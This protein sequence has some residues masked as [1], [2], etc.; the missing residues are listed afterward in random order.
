M[1]ECECE[2]DKDKSEAGHNFIV[3]PKTLVGNLVCTG[4]NPLSSLQFFP[5]SYLLSSWVLL[6]FPIL[7]SCPLLWGLSLPSH[8]PFLLPSLFPT[9]LA[10]LPTPL[11][12]FPDGSQR[13]KSFPSFPTLAADSR[14]PF[15]EPPRPS[16]IDRMVFPGVP[17]VSENDRPFFPEFPWRFPA[18]PLAFCVL[19]RSSASQT[20]QKRST[21]K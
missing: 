6:W 1:C 8:S 3:E 4:M 19:V 17:V 9:S 21:I 16:G 5:N 20:C 12:T 14:I 11:V 10:T 13:F 18:L 15:P 2:L 7:R